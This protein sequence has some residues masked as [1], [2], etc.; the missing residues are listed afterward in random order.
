MEPPNLEFLISDYLDF[1]FLGFLYKIGLIG[2][3][4]GYIKSKAENY[5]RYSFQGCACDRGNRF[6]CINSH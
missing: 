1:I 3:I 6:A 2:R 4:K 5:W